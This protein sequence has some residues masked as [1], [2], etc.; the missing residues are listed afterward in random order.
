M[1]KAL[2]NTGNF[3]R[4][5]R[6]EKE[7]FC[8]GPLAKQAGSDACDSAKAMNRAGHALRRAPSKPSYREQKTCLRKLKRGIIFTLEGLQKRKASFG[9][10]S[11]TP[12]AGIMESFAG[13]SDCSAA[14]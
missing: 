13:C 4:C 2:L 8:A 7:D 6:E 12:T 9:R 5:L 14:S 10:S 1:G 3:E 11:L